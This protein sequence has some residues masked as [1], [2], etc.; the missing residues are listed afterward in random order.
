MGP[1]CLLVT[2]PPGHPR[3]KPRSDI[4]GH[5]SRSASLRRTHFTIDIDEND[6]ATVVFGNGTFGAIP[7]RG[8]MTATYRVGGGPEGN[9]GPD[10]IVSIA[11]APGLAGLGAKVTNPGPATGGAERESI[12]HAVEHA[13]AVFRSQHRAVTIGDYEALARS[14]DGVGKVRAAATGWNRVTLYVAPSGGP[15][16][17][18]PATE[19]RRKYVSDTLDSDSNGSSKTNG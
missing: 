3:I 13:P 10:T 14:F 4:P 2:S 5:P 15:G 19:P 16:N 17:V 11:D 7:G 18:D 9:V 6:Q 12:E 8:A 1:G